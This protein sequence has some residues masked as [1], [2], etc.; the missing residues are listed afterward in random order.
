MVDF[1]WGF[2]RPWEAEVFL[3]ALQGFVTN[4]AVVVL[5]MISGDDAIPSRTLKDERHVRH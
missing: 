1:H 5:R 2:D 4:P 3:D